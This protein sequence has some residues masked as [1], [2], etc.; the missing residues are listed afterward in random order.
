MH[1]HFGEVRA[2]I[3]YT[4]FFVDS[5]PT[6][7]GV[8]RAIDAAEFRRVYGCIDAIGIARRNAE[9][10]S[11]QTLLECRKPF[12][13]LSPCVAAVGRFVETAAGPL[14]LA[15]LPRPQSRS[16]HIGVN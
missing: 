4:R 6:F 1:F 13:K 10:D 9:T 2:A 8:V 15:V 11:S 16:P 12:R 3:P 5:P 7:P 14:P